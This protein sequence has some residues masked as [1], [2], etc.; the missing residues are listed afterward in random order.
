VSLFELDPVPVDPPVKLSVDQRR[1]IRRAAALADGRHPLMGGPVDPDHTCGDCTHHFSH[2]RNG[3]WH[4][5]ELNATGGPATDI[6]VSWPA[7]SKWA[8]IIGD[9]T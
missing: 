5:C 7:C 4:K 6:R 8:P 1:T 3:T 2:T 9:D